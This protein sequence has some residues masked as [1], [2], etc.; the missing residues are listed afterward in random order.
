MQ[1]DVAPV[2]GV[3]K[4]PVYLATQ[5]GVKRVPFGHCA[6]L[7]RAVHGASREFLGHLHV[8]LVERVNTQDGACG[9][10]RNL[11]HEHCSDQVGDVTES[12][13]DHWMPRGL[14]SCR[15]IIQIVAAE[16]DQQEAAIRAVGRSGVCRLAPN[17]HDAPAILARGLG[18]ELFDPR[19]KRPQI[20]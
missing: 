6:G 17:G 12:H 14:E 2:H 11:Q 9:C 19:R 8:W 15:V 10:D 13:A 16:L 1:A 20:G 5:F 18:H 4:P 7:Q 3:A